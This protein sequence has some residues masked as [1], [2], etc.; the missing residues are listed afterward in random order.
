M[1]KVW[2]LKDYAFAE[3]TACPRKQLLCWAPRLDPAGDEELCGEN[4]AWITGRFEFFVTFQV[5]HSRRTGQPEVGAFKL[6]GSPH[7]RVI[8]TLMG[9]GDQASC[10][11]AGSRC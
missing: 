6:D 9:S 8:L 4:S 1:R 5:E 3:S 10:R 11:R 2:A 7:G